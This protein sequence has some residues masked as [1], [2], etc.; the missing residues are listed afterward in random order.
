MADRRVRHWRAW[1][2]NGGLGAVALGCLALVRPAPHWHGTDAELHVAV[3]A[4]LGVA[5]LAALAAVAVAAV[6]LALWLGACKVAAERR[7]G[8]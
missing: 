4:T 2:R 8:R 3:W 1:R 6:P 7:R 5:V